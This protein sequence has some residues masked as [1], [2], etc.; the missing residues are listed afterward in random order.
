[1]FLSSHLLGQK[2]PEQEIEIVESLGTSTAV[3]QLHLTQLSLRLLAGEGAQL[4]PPAQVKLREEPRKTAEEI[5]V[6]EEQDRPG[7]TQ[8]LAEQALGGGVEQRKTRHLSKTRLLTKT[9][10]ERFTEEEVCVLIVQLCS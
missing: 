10:M 7:R 5:E 1:M 9:R 6:G 3:L 8:P 2:C 4:R